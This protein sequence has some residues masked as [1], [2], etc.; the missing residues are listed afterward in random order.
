MGFVSF[1]NSESAQKLLN[2]YKFNPDLLGIVNLSNQ[3]CNFVKPLLNK[4][5]KKMFNDVKEQRNQKIDAYNDIAHS[6]F[7]SQDLDDTQMDGGE[8]D[9][10]NSHVIEWL[11]MYNQFES[12]L[13]F[14][15]MIETEKKEIMDKLDKHSAQLLFTYVLEDYLSRNFPELD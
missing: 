7:A 6:Q 3:Q 8:Q 2:E 14:I 10:I 13:M 11:N 5:E 4:F 1:K 12:P 9:D 15:E